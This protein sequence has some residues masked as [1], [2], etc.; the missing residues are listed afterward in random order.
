MN[1]IPEGYFTQLTAE[2]KEWATCAASP[3]AVEIFLV[4]ETSSPALGTNQPLYPIRTGD[5]FPFMVGLGREADLP[6]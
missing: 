4:S 5:I 3:I 2:A 6:F 1:H